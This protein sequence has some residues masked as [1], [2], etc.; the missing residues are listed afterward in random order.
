MFSITLSILRNAYSVVPTKKL[1][2]RPCTETE[3]IH[4]QRITQGR[5]ICKVIRKDAIKSNNMQQ[6]TAELG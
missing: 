5:E 1:N 6:N 4:S 2:D 3:Q